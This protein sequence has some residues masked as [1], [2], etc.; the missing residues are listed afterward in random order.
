VATRRDTPGSLDIPPARPT[1][2]LHPRVVDGTVAER[3][4][5][6]YEHLLMEL[7]DLFASPFARLPAGACPWALMVEAEDKQSLINRP[8]LHRI[9]RSTCGISPTPRFP[10]HRSIKHVHYERDWSGFPFTISFANDLTWLGQAVRDALERIYG[11]HRELRRYG[12]QCRWLQLP[13]EESADLTV[14]GRRA[15]VRN[16]RKSPGSPHSR[17][18]TPGRH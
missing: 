10:A 7:G 15:G 4:R 3:R 6:N 11:R 12:T 13:A 17:D 8:P 1:R 18:V 14:V 16:P 2:F 9:G 5:Q